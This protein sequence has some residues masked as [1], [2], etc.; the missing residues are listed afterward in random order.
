MNIMIYFDPRGTVMVIQDLL[1]KRNDLSS[2]VVHLTKK[3]EHG[4][5]KENL[6]S[7]LSSS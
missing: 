5:T 4:T 3:D 7:I 2:F 1:S 6:T